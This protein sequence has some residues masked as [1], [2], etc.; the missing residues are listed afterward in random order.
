MSNIRFADL[1]TTTSTTTSSKT[2]STSK[3]TTTA[4]HNKA[5]NKRQ[6][7][8]STFS[9]P[10]SHH[11]AT[12]AYLISSLPYR[13]DSAI[14]VAEMSQRF[15]VFKRVTQG[16][17]IVIGSWL[18]AYSD[19]VIN[20]RSLGN[21]GSMTNIYTYAGKTFYGVG[22]GFPLLLGLPEDTLKCSADDFLKT[23]DKYQLTSGLGD[24]L[25]SSLSVAAIKSIVSEFNIWVRTKLACILD[26]EAE[27]KE[28]AAIGFA[29]EELNTAMNL[30]I[31][32]EASERSNLRRM[33]KFS[34]DNVIF[35]GSG[36]G[37]QLEERVAQ[38]MK[39]QKLLRR[40]F[41]SE[42]RDVVDFDETEQN[43]LY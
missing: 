14:E 34:R 10:K 12:I 6:S 19:F 23:L 42:N 25:S 11:D 15:K 2:S 8:S 39:N 43:E 33:E 40:K 35:S 16:W 29:L 5:R 27:I 7:S 18:D 20:N 30:R 21:F 9:D 41:E 32:A 1:T 17:S 37:D 31:E 26:F 28:A 22:F 38:K 36:F 3:T 13:I 24:L 4:H